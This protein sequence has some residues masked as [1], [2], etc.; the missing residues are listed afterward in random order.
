MQCLPISEFCSVFISLLV[1]LSLSLVSVPRAFSCFSCG[2]VD[3][4]NSKSKADQRDFLNRTRQY[5]DINAL[6]SLACER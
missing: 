3:C 2:M 5:N 4:F 1:V 6:E